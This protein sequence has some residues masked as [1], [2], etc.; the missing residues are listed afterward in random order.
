[1]TCRCAETP[2]K[3]SRSRFFTG[4]WVDEMVDEWLAVSRCSPQAAIRFLGGQA[5]GDAACCS[6][7]ADDAQVGVVLYRGQDLACH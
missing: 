5:A 6:S 3:S 2:Q 4:D 1:M 7:A